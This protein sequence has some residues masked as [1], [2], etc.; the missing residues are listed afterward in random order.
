MV[1]APLEGIALG[2]VAVLAG[3][4]MMLLVQGHRGLA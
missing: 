2:C 1:G 3:S 4:G